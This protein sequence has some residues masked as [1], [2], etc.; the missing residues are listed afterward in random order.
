MKSIIK[1]ESATKKEEI[2]SSEEIVQLKK[3][4]LNA[5]NQLQE[6]KTFRNQNTGKRYQRQEFGLLMEMIQNSGINK[7]QIAKFLVKTPQYK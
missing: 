4:V 7:A 1:K 5:E 6:K 2:S 3:E